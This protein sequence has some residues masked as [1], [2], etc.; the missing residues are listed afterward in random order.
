MLG[1]KVKLKDAEKVKKNLLAKEIYNRYYKPIK[2]KTHIIFPVLEK[3]DTK[4]GHFL[5]ENF[6]KIEKQT[7]QDKLKEKIPEN[8]FS[9]LP[10]SYDIIGDI[11]ILEI[12]DDLI[13]YEK[14]IAKSILETHPQVKTILKKSGIHEGEFR[15]QKLEH[16]SGEKT[17]ET[18]Y[19]ENNIKLKLDVE[20]VYFSPRSSTERKRIFSQVKKGEKVLVMFS[21]CAPFVLTIAKNT[22]AEKIIGIEKNPIAH[23]YAVENLNLNKLKN[24]ELIQGDVK[25]IIPRL[26]QNY[27]RI[28]MPLPKDAATFLDLA[29]QVAKK[30]TIIHLYDFEHEEEIDLIKEKI[31]KEAEKAKIDYEILDIVKCGQYSPGK[32]RICADFKIL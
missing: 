2:T 27:D 15:L 21:G 32:F 19:K 14:E 10:S 9:E 28:I 7:Y 26:D 1:I 8:L 30:D 25:D 3:I 23:K 20:K 16:L 6:E 24:V 11:I 12:K 4:E 18:T 13:K 29:F 17:K 5:E 31:K 22:D